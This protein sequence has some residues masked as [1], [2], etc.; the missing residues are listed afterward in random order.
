M[1]LKN[2]QEKL[3][4]KINEL[5][6]LYE[7]SNL[8]SK[9]DSVSKETLLNVIT[10]TKKAW[11]H[12][13]NIIVEL[14]VRDYH[15]ATSKKI[16]S[17]IY[18]TSDITIKKVVTGWIKIYYP[19]EKYTQKDLN[20]DEQKLLDTIAIEIGNYIEKYET[21]ERKALLR[22]SIERMQRLIHLGE[23]SAGIAHEINNALSNILGFAELIKERNTDTEIDHDISIIINSIIY[24]REIV[25]KMMFFSNEMPHKIEFQEIKPIFSFALSFL[26][27]NFLRKRIKYLLFFQNENIIAK[28]DSVQI[29]QVLFNLLLNAIYASPEDSIITII[30]N[31]D[32]DFLYIKIEDQGTGVPGD[33]KEKIFT[34]FF[35]TKPIN[36]GQ[37]LG[38]SVV[39]EIITRHNGEILIEDNFPNG[40]IFT[41]KIPLN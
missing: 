36:N 9:S 37:G 35:S 19:Q 41:I 29:T 34:P 38:L 14:Q 30:I 4:E 7:I 6:C 20:E 25:K 26:K 12:H 11:K 24:S 17:G 1:K 28:V 22:S 15:L 27:S 2:T 8:I 32:N 13:K 40:A 18:Q 10:S 39:N 31:S 3:N 5:S 16:T 33:L 23:M 21:L